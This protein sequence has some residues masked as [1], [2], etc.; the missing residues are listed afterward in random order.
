ML[1]RERFYHMVKDALRKCGFVGEVMVRHDDGAEAVG[2]VGEPS[3][4]DL[5][6]EIRFSPLAGSLGETRREK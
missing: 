3:G 4:A 6:C 5:N 1:Q 2:W